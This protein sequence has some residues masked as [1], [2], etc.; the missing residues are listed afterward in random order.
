MYERFQGDPILYFFPRMPAMLLNSFIH[1][2]PHS[3]GNTQ[4][5]GCSVAWLYMFLCVHVLLFRVFHAYC[6]HGVH[7]SGPSQPYIRCFWFL[8][9]YWK[10]NNFVVVV[11]GVA[12][13]GVQW[14][15]HSWTRI[16]E[17][18]SN[19][20]YNFFCLRHHILWGYETFFF[21]L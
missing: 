1:S 10:I 13:A 9:S 15:T 17:V 5:A 18:W 8:V 3:A 14:R 4:A 21:T 6:M 19:M 16:Y 2:T 20:N 12:V 11:V 7:G